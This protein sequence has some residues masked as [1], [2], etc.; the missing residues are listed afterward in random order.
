MEKTRTKTLHREKC[1][2]KA[3]KSKK[4]QFGDTI[5]LFGRYGFEWMVTV[6]KKYDPIL[7]TNV[8]PNREAATRYYN[9]LH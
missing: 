3:R 2:P 5:S 1:T 6:E 7:K 8:F 4:N 9:Q